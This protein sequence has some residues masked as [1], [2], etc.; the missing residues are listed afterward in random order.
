[1]YR[2][3]MVANGVERERVRQMIR[4]QVKLGNLEAARQLADR[5]GIPNIERLDLGI[6]LSNNPKHN[7]LPQNMA[8]V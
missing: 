6:E 5:H 1:M 2:Q 8:S 7:K 3:D 4:Q